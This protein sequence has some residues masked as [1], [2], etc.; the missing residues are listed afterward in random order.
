MPERLGSIQ[1]MLHI[2]VCM[3]LPHQSLLDACSVARL[4]TRAAGARQARSPEP[5]GWPQVAMLVGGA[6]WQRQKGVT[7]LWEGPQEGPALGV[8]LSGLECE[9]ASK[10]EVCS[11][12]SHLT[13]L[14]R[15]VVGDCRAHVIGSSFCHLHEP[16]QS[17]QACGQ[18]GA[19]PHWEHDCWCP[20]CRCCSHRS[21]DGPP[22]CLCA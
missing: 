21:L 4:V 8:G 3:S 7:G 19:G 12:I 13:G 1:G 16:L 10:T 18:R 11:S 5:V 17:T 20:P 9:P 14:R 15:A 22:Q 2:L 6:A